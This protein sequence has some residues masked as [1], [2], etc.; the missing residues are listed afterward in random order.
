ME[1]LTSIPMIKNLSVLAVFAYSVILA[2][3]SVL[4]ETGKAP[5]GSFQKLPDGKWNVV[6]PIKIE[7]GEA[8]VILKPGTAIGPGTG[9]AGVDIYAALQKSC[10]QAGNSPIGG[11]RQ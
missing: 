8:S 11:G 7:H 3:P 6:K 10:Q 1:R 9:I 4:A 5:C 2:S